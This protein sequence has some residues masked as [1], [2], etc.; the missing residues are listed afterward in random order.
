MI[1]KNKYKIIYKTG[2]KMQGNMERGA[3]RAKIG[4]STGDENDSKTGVTDK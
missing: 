4:S 3:H 1:K 2:A